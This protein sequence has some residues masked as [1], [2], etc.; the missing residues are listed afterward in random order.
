MTPGPEGGKPDPSEVPTEA[1]F[2]SSAEAGSPGVPIPPGTVFA[3]RY[4]VQRLA[5]R[6]GMG[7]VYQAEDLLLAQPVALKF[8]PAGVGRD[9]ALRSRLYSEVRTARRVSHP[10]VCRVYDVGEADG[11]HFL[12]M[13]WIE[14]EDLGTLL[15]R[16][17]YLARD[18]ALDVARQLAAGLAAAHDEGVLHHDLKPSN[19]ML[20]ARGVV[21]IADFGIAEVARA[22][23]GRRAREGTP[24]YMAP[25]QLAGGEVTARSDVYSLGLVLYEVFTGRPAYPQAGSVEEIA[26][27]RSSPP[28]PL[29]QLVP[30]IEPA[31][32]QLVL[33]CLETDPIRRPPSGREVASAL[34][35]GESLAEA[36][37]AAQRRA[38]R[39][40]AFRE[41]LSELRRTGLL[42]IGEAELAAVDSYHAGVLSDLVHRYDVDVSERG[43]QLSLGLRM[44]SLVGALALAA[45][46][47]F[48]FYRI[49]GLVSPSVQ[50]GILAAAPVVGLLATWAVGS[51][52]RSGSFT[53]MA[54]VFALACMFLDVT[55][56]GSTLNLAPGVYG[57]L[58]CSIFALIVAYSHR[59]RLLLVLGLLFGI[60]FI[61]GRVFLWAGGDWMNFPERPENFL[62]AAL[63]LVLVPIRFAGRQPQGFEA[64]WRILGTGLVFLVIFVISISGHLSY[65]SFDPDTTRAGYQIAGFVASAAAIALG[66][67]RRWKDSVYAGTVFFI[68]MLHLKFVDWWWDWMPRY[69]FFLI[70]AATAIGTVILLTRLRG[71]LSRLDDAV[72]P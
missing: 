45:S 33:R 46:V 62:P 70:V 8:L 50:I 36:A 26:R 3:G 40:A 7:E 72:R 32:E 29:S 44:V 23:R 54:A 1:A 64:L 65:L 61:A 31:V 18:R 41:E 19:V 47:F 16:K 68:A 24:S 27:Q 55:L 66:V 11:R 5:G 12:S 14:G 60:G 15:R 49:W 52:D 51:W 63:L 17:G 39:I 42:R 67:T 58:A 6:G 25:E 9:E 37:A 48:F 35:G 38:D 53:V 56:L 43:K 22:I 30:G 59:L 20:D 28:A 2:D 21:R 13:E 71:T 69:L 34:P 57:L 4:R 10:N